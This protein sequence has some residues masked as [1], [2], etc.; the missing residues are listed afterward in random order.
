[1]DQHD[2]LMNLLFKKNNKFDSWDN[3]PNKIIVGIE[4]EYLVANKFN[5]KIS[6]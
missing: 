6:L 1:M 4:L 3:D 5:H 2:K